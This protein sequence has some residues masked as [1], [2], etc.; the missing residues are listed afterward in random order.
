MIY[1]WWLLTMI[2]FA[3]AFPAS[4][5]IIL[6]YLPLIIRNHIVAA[7]VMT[8]DQNDFNAWGVWNEK[9]SGLLYF[10]FLCPFA[11]WVCLRRSMISKL[12]MVPNELAPLSTIIF[13]A[14]SV[15]INIK[16]KKIILLHI[17]LNTLNKL[18]VKDN[19]L[20]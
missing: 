18:K 5:F 17:S 19:K 20:V 6:L 14:V 11:H 16:L 8:I 10:I 4:W 15:I 2:S 3:D 7:E 9:M 13:N 1:V 12:A